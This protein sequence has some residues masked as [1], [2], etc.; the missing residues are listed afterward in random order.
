MASKSQ[1]LGL[2]RFTGLLVV[3]GGIAGATLISDPGQAL[4]NAGTIPDF[5][6]YCRAVY[7]GSQYVRRANRNGFAPR[8]RQSRTEHDIGA[9]SIC[10]WWTRSPAHHWRKNRRHERIALHCNGR[11]LAYPSPNPNPRGARGGSGGKPKIGSAYRRFPNARGRAGVAKR[12]SVA[13]STSWGGKYGG[14]MRRIYVP[15]DVGRYGKCSNYGWWSGLSY[16]GVRLPRPG[17]WVYVYP[18]WY[19]WYRRT[20]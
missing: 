3:A 9:R 12:V 8:C 13:C 15:G 19:V 11:K 18:N 20:R 2:G 10:R 14:F 5:N 6:S 17:F 1:A 7:S 4:A 16:K